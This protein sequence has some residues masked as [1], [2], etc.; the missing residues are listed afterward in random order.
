MSHVGQARCDDPIYIKLWILLPASC[1]KKEETS[2][3]ALKYLSICDT[4]ISR[5]IRLHILAFHSNFVFQMLPDLQNKN[6]PKERRKK[7]N[8]L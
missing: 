4:N 8:L 6:K 2:F 7:I 1:E 5:E 3:V